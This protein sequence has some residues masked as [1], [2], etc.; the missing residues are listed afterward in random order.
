MKNILKLILIFA[1]LNV[2]AQSP[3]APSDFVNGIKLSEATQ[4]TTAERVPVIDT[5]LV[6]DSWISSEDFLS[7]VDLEFV[8]ENGNTTTNDV[9]F[10]DSNIIVKS[11]NYTGSTFAR[12]DY[13]YSP[14][15]FANWDNVT[16]ALYFSFPKDT[17]QGRTQI[18]FEITRGSNQ[19]VLERFSLSF[20]N[21]GVL[22]LHK[23]TGQG[24]PFLNTIGMY[25]D[26]SRLYFVINSSFENLQHL[27]LKVNRAK[28]ARAQSICLE[29]WESGYLTDLSGLTKIGFNA[30]KTEDGS[31]A[32]VNT[33]DN[34]IPRSKED[35]I[36]TNGKVGFGTSNPT[37]AA[38]VLTTDPSLDYFKISSSE[39]TKGDVMTVHGST[40]DVEIGNSLEVTGSFRDSNSSEGLLG[41][42]LTSTV[43]G[44]EWSEG[45]LFYGRN[46]YSTTQ[47]LL[48]TLNTLQPIISE[49]ETV[50]NSFVAD[51]TNT[52]FEATI[53]GVYRLEAI[54]QFING[55]G[56]SK[57]E[58]CWQIDTGGGF[59]TDPQSVI[60][61]T[62]K[63]D[64]E[65]VISCVTS[66][67][68]NVGDKVRA[69]WAS[70]NNNTEINTLIT[71][72]GNTAP[73]VQ[74]FITFIG[75]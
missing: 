69:M 1:T 36:Y 70:D 34:K 73:S 31:H 75:K 12:Q 49:V 7:G 4:V 2:A 19:T 61:D 3:N 50:N 33:S 71:V 28:F 51:V 17:Q 5:D 18:D 68:L 30:T 43:T 58:Q 29:N 15:S 64:T 67:S 32:F 39:A 44:T 6:I 57:I 13:V 20:Y 62:F 21:T 26:A 38:E 35:D 8:T 72:T 48:I 14:T 63:K 45:G 54:P 46:S 22:S 11:A 16:G 52:E 65:G 56:D 40:G 53:A 41:R 74:H 10:N 66:L 37:A 27:G 23:Y 60:E 59:V 25:Q 55:G 9:I 42:V 47:Q 24:V